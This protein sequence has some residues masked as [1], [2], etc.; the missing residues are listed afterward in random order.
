MPDPR[1]TFGN[2][3]EDTAEAF[4][5][6]LGY[7]ILERQ[8]TTPFGEIDLIAMDRDEVVFIEVKA[9]RSSAFGFPEESVTP[10][11]V[12]KIAK[13]GQLFLQ[14]FPREPVYRIDVLAIEYSDGEPAFT[15]IRSVG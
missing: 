4:F 13:A 12:R 9:R 14:R 11:K 15:H 10:G 7:R 2:R 6:G 5:R 3:A 8:F 1:R